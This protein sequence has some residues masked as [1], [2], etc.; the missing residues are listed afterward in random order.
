MRQ[1]Y[2]NNRGTDIFCSVDGGSLGVCAHPGDVNEW[3]L[4]AG[5]QGCIIRLLQRE[6]Q[7]IFANREADALGGR[8]AEEFDEAVVA[9]ASAHGVLRTEALRGDFER[10]AHVIIEAADEAPVF[11]VKN[12]TEFELELYGRVVRFAV[13]A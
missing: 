8:A 12:A 2:A 13:V 6:D 3:R 1:F 11:L 10:S 5:G 7:A 4:F 9:A